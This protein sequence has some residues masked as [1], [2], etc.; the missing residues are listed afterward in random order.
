MLTRYPAML[1]SLVV[2]VIGMMPSNPQVVTVIAPTIMPPAVRVKGGTSE[3]VFS[4]IRK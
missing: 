1:R 4:E 3:S 2:I